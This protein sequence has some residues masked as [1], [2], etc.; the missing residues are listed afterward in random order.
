MKKNY[1]TF[2]N[3][4]N[5]IKKPNIHAFAVKERKDGENWAEKIFLKK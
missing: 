1:L 2:R 4:W 3:L 5:N